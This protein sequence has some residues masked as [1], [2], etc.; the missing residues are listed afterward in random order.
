MFEISPFFKVTV[1]V[2]APQR[3]PF[4]A[5]SYVPPVKDPLTP[6]ATGTGVAV[7]LVGVGVG[8]WLGVDAGVDA[9]VD[10]VDEVVVF[11][12]DGAA[13]AFLVVTAFGVALGVLGV[14]TVDFFGVGV[15]VE[16]VVLAVAE[17]VLVAV[18]DVDV[19]GDETGVALEVSV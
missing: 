14:E 6:D 18:A 17:G 16:T 1:T 10:G 3:R 5:A 13:E 9:G 15:V 8:V 7:V 4:C 19:E 2:T 11:V 12:A